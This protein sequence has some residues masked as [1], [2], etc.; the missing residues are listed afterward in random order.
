MYSLCCFRGEGTFA[1]CSSDDWGPWP[2]DEYDDYDDAAEFEDIH[3][4]F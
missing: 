2:G 1:A 3:D 4:E